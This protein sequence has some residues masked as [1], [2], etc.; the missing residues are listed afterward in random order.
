M[1]LN[2]IKFKLFLMSVF[3]LIV[4]TLCLDVFVGMHMKNKGEEDI[5]RFEAEEIQT[6]KDGI[7]N[8]TDIA[9]H[10]VESLYEESRPENVGKVLKRQAETFHQY[11]LKYHRNLT[12]G[13]AYISEFEA[14]SALKKLVKAY[15]YNNGVGYYWINDFDNKMVMHPIKPSLDGETFVNSEK[16]PFVELAT[17]A[18]KGGKK[19]AYITY[20]F[21]N[22]K[23]GEYEKKISYVFVFEP[24]NWI[25]GTGDY[26]SNINGK[27]QEQAKDILSG[28][29]Y[30][31]DG[32]FFIVDYSG[33]P[34]LYPENESFEGKDMRSHR[35][36]DGTMLFQQ[37]LDTAKS[38]RGAIK[39]T[40]DTDRPHL[41][42]VV[43]VKGM[44]EWGWAVGT[45]TVFDMQKLKAEEAALMKDV[46]KTI[47]TVSILSLV[48]I[49]AI[50]LFSQFMAA[51]M[52]K[53]IIM[54]NELLREMSEGEGDLTKE[55]PV[56]GSD[57]I[58]MLCSHFNTFIAKLRDIIENVKQSA[59]SVA[60][61][62]T[63]LAS[64]TEQLSSTFNEQA[65]Q[66]SEVATATEEM[67]TTSTE[68][69]TSLEDV[70]EKTSSAKESTDAGVENLQRIINEMNLI[71][72]S[73]NTL[74]ETVNSLSGSSEDIGNILNVID[75][76]A[77][78]TNL[79]A[80]NA[81]IEAARAGEHGRGFAVV[82][83]EVRKL[84][85]RTQRA[86]GEISEIINGLRA[87]TKTATQNMESARE[88]VDNGMKAINTTERSFGEIV[89]S[90][91]MIHDSNAAVGTA[92]TQQAQAVNEIND[93][94]Q[95]ISSG[96][97]QSSAAVKEVTATVGDL[98]KQA[99]ELR[100]LV[101]RFKTM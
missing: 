61:G 81:A 49:I 73:V 90:V 88:R 86:T 72:E 80:L 53:N 5:H 43:H 1:K 78:Q 48:L 26:I 21:L 66:I 62:S 82:A 18:L 11:M 17:E 34:I 75:D 94:A 52:A 99:D 9:F 89:E 25:V 96:V 51:R 3:P 85:E 64:T 6:T 67:S 83:D 39:Y 76:I 74:G 29:R 45:Y 19:E 70:N 14:A 101:G 28:L 7:R 35:A 97:E 91:T 31:D 95:F 33:V 65:G 87:E 56:S 79:L 2:S 57:E 16:V 12:E 50:G 93:S 15:R 58:G 84:A 63:E 24:F 44:D 98:Q 77:E 42:R 23:S 69:V 60:S 10:A 47:T 37:I 100:Y 92:I 54:V 4:L 71:N 40:P 55:M 46:W 30:G 32:R 59:E 27:L 8:S 22:P 13:N 20:E 68:I 41:H 38:G 36:E